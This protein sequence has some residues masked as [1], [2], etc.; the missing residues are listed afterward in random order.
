MSINSTHTR[1]LR[2]AYSTKSG[3]GGTGIE[4]SGASSRATAAER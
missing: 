1:W 3:F 2:R 4:H